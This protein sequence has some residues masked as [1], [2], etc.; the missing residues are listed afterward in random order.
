[1]CKLDRGILFTYFSYIKSEWKDGEPFKG[2]TTINIS[3]PIFTLAF[4]VAFFI[5][6]YYYRY[7]N[8]YLLNRSIC[9]LKMAKV[10]VV[11]VKYINGFS[12]LLFG[13]QM[14]IFFTKNL[15]SKECY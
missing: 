9:L 14:P 1:V 13:L 8:G 10:S 11:V 12:A 4:M 7:S 2:H 15:K 5:L 6:I 3:I